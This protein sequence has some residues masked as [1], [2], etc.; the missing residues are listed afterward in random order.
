M[1]STRYGKNMISKKIKIV[2]IVTIKKN[3]D[4]LII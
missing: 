1:T 3:L 2:A 4:Q